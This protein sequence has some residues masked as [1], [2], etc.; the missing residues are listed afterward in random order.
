MN[1]HRLALL[2]LVALAAGCGSG[3]KPPATT[4][5]PTTTAVAKTMTLTVFRVVNGALRAE[6][7]RVPETQAVAGAALTA[8][9]I[10][11]RVTIDSGTAHVDLENADPAETAEI[12]YTLTQFPSVHRV[13][14]AG[15]PALTRAD[16]V[17]FAPVI[18]IERP[19]AG[20]S[21]PES[22]TVSGTASVFEATLVVELRRDGAVLSKHTVTA[23][24]GGPARGT[25]SVLLQAPSPG[26]ATVVAYAPS[27]EDGT[28]QHQQET[29]VTVLKP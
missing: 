17:A 24:E 29:A 8:L 13:D 10:D 23:S 25:F 26:A 9:G 18:L 15:R 19:A 6:A 14:L 20:S 27:A 1:K 4:T 2:L 22:F 7:V 11:A 16:V 21:V 5:Q 12:V 28:P 3:S